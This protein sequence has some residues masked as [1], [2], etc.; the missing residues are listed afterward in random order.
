MNCATCKKPMVALEL[1][2]IE[3]DHCLACGSTWLDNGELELFVE[4]TGK[5]DHLLDSIKPDKNNKEKKKRCP[6]CW[7]KMEKVTCGIENKITLD[8]CKKNDGVWFDKGELKEILKM[9]CGDKE[10]KV[11]HLL[12]DMFASYD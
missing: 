5:K 7:K 9:S 3:I 12:K 11:L 8:R 1:E 2:G 4:G 10:S 6:I